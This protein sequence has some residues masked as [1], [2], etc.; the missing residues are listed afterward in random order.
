MR[1]LAAALVSASLL[2]CCHS[3]RAEAPR[4]PFGLWRVADGSALIEIKPCGRA[5]CGYVASAPAPGPGEKSAIGQKILLDMQR[6]GAVWRGPIF[7][8]DDGKTYESEIAVG[9]E[10]HLKIKGCLPGGGLCGGENWK[11]E[12]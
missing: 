9:D 2:A 4:A 11:R 6:Q 5:L 8:L 7:N 3:V 1:M 12:R 10:A